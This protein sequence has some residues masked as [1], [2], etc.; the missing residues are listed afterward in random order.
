M[1]CMQ[2]YCQMSGSKV[3]CEPPMVCVWI[4]RRGSGQGRCVSALCP[5]AL[6]FS[7]RNTRAGGGDGASRLARAERFTS[8]SRVGEL[9]PCDELLHACVLLDRRRR[10]SSHT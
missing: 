1:E 4:D 2:S 6:F 8:V 7:A 9:P 3:C 5:M 10:G